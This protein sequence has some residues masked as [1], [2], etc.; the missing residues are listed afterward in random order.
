MEASR[1]N[2]ISICALR[3]GRT[4]LG[5]SEAGD[6]A[7]RVGDDDGLA[8]LHI[9]EQP[10]QM[11]LGPRCPDFAHDFPFRLVELTGQKWDL[12]AIYQLAG[13]ATR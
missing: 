1:T 12:M 3:A 9:V 8:A 5:Q 7:A 11:G 10:G 13:R 2:G 4:V 6:G